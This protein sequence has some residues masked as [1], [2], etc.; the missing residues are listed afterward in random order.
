MTLVL[1]HGCGTDCHFWDELLPQLDGLEILAPSLPGRADSG[2]EP[3]PTAPMPTA[4]DAALWLRSYLA[5]RSVQRAIV[6]GHS[7]GGGIAI[8]FA[9]QPGAEGMPSLDGLV[10][11]STGARLRVAA[12]ILEAARAAAQS[13]VPADLG[14]FSYQHD[15]DPALVE[16]I[17]AKAR[18]TPVATTLCDWLATD[19]FDRLSDVGKVRTRTLVVGGTEDRLTPPKYSEYLART[20]AGATLALIPG[21][22][23]MLPIEHARELGAQLRQ[24][25][26]TSR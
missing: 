3:M 20:I 12:P 10:L 21:A 5:Q 17:E 8:E 11:V 24:F 6:V 16:R 25:V 4:L 2:T 1:V 9:L 7:F 23:H 26:R 19:A 14:R 15:A 22:G 13:G 18:K